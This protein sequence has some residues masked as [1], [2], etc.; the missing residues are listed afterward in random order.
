MRSFKSHFLSRILLPAA[1]LALA[2][3]APALGHCSNIIRTDAPITEFKGVWIASEPLLG[4]WENASSLYGCT[5]VFPGTDYFYTGVSF[6][7]THSGCFQDQRQTRQDQVVNTQ[8]GEIRSKGMPYEAHQTLSNLSYTSQE[9]G[10]SPSF[11]V[12]MN[13]GRHSSTQNGS[14]VG[15]YAR[16]NSG[17]SVGG[18][19]STPDGDRVLIY[20][21]KTGVI[22]AAGACSVRLGITRMGGWT[23]GATV[24]KTATAFGSNANVL[25]LFDR[26]GKPSKVYTMSKGSASDGG[27]YRESAADCSDMRAFYDDTGLF[28][29]A[30][31]TP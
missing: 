20:F 22:S 18:L 16:S 8:T 1:A 3:T 6:Q 27:Y 19:V 24:T 25:T 29:K 21:G 11:S 13:A 9:I 7:Q 5:N 26:S 23:P 17:V 2:A 30:T 14:Y 4:P 31:L 28:T 15:M 10:T 12:I